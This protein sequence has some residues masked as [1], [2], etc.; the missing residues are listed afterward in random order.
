MPPARVQRPAQLEPV[1]ARHFAARDRQE[2]GQR[3]LGGEQV[4]MGVVERRASGCS[5]RRTGAAACCK[6]PKIHVAGQL[7]RP[8]R[9]R[10]A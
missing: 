10:L 8:G 3:R 2:T 1:P 6:A 5:R 7:G 9:Q 4:V